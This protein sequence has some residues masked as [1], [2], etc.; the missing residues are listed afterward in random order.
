MISITQL[1]NFIYLIA[2]PKYCN[3]INKVLSNK[4]ESSNNN[5]VFKMITQFLKKNCYYF[6]SKVSIAC[7]KA[8]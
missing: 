2:L 4:F 5:F 8:W 7:A 3:E 1:D 6:F